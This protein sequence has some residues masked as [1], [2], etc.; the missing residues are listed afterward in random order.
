[1]GPTR[2]A[3]ASP[4]AVEPVAGHGPAGEGF[5]RGGR[6]PAPGQGWQGG[7]I[8][9][10]QGQVSFVAIGIEQPGTDGSGLVGRVVGQAQHQQVPGSGGGYVG[11][12]LPFLGLG[13]L[14]LE[15]GLAADAPVGVEVQVEPRP[16][17]PGGLPAA[18]ELAQAG[19][20]RRLAL[21]EE[22]A[23][24]HRVFQALAAIHRDHRNRRLGR[25]AVELVVGGHGAVLG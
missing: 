14:V 4:A 9:A 12:S 18:T 20:D 5:R 25:I 23:D 7:G 24:H 21:P 13:G 11:Q 15:A 2:I 8:E 16:A 6:L 10:L 22:R 3:A 1:M 17:G 19:L